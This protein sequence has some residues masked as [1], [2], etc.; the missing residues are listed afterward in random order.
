M[1]EADQVKFAWHGVQLPPN[2]LRGDKQST[3]N[4]RAPF[5]SRKRPAVQCVQSA[6]TSIY[7]LGQ[8]GEE[9]GSEQRVLHLATVSKKGAVHPTGCNQMQHDFEICDAVTS[10]SAIIQADFQGAAAGCRDLA[11]TRHPN[12]TS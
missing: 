2:S 12:P 6:M 3:I 9:F 1:D 5:Q 11:G 4:H 10:A 8:R 7:P